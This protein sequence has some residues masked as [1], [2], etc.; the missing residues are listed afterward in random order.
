MTKRRHASIGIQGLL[1][2]FLLAGSVPAGRS[3]IN[4]A[5]PGTPNRLDSLRGTG[6]LDE[7]RQRRILR[8]LVEYSPTY[9]FFSDG[10][11]K[12]FEYELLSRF[13]E[14]LNRDVR[15]EDRKIHV[16]FT[17]VRFEDLLPYLVE[18]RGD[19]AAAGLT[20][21]A[22]RREI[23]AFTDP[24]LPDVDEVV[25]TAKHVQ[26]LRTPADLSGRSVYVLPSTS[27]AQHLEELNRAFGRAGRAPVRIV[28][29]DPDLNTEGILELVNA[30][31][32]DITV[33]DRHVAEIWAA[34]LTDMVVRTDLR[35]ARSGD[36][37]WA[38]RKDNPE[39]LSELNAYVK[40]IR[41]GTLLGNIFFRR[42]YRDTR[43]I[44]NPLTPSEMGKLKRYRPLFQKYAAEYGMDW[45]ALAAQ[46]YQESRLDQD[47]R[48]P[49]GAVGIM[50]LMPSTAADKAVAIPDISTAE[51]N[52]H[53]GV[54]Y[55]AWLRDT[56][57]DDPDLPDEVRWDFTLAA[58]NLGPGRVRRLREAAKAS[59]LDPNRWFFNVEQ[60][61]LKTAGP[62][63]VRYVSNINKYYIA[64]SMAE[65]SRSLGKEIRKR[66]LARN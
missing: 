35:I 10:E 49:T 46:A 47:C 3:Q 2:L 31:V 36:I 59:G 63:P 53:A 44:R 50:Q 32:V 57:F 23:V 9:F 29:A 66:I 16:I 45:M 14:R 52:I 37:A 27:F 21:T 20:I 12:G 34:G 43:W 22:E 58:Y 41:R 55:M 42:Y 48:S 6:D 24:Y 54:K 60:I 1:V 39:L 11:P 8:V 65:K 33:A 19:I 28:P 5:V 4:G 7:I 15:S 30:G 40:T 13:E 62:E 64:Y 25:V 56:Y 18:G 61:A 26:G 38:V 51:N 17:P